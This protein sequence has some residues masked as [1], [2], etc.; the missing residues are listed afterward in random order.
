MRRSLWLAV[1][2]AVP[3]VGQVQ[4]PAVVQ[5]VCGACHPVETATSQRRTRAEWQENIGQMVAR[6]AKGT[7]EEL[8]AVLDYFARNNGPVTAPSPAS[9]TG[10]PPAGGPPPGGRA[11]R[12]AAYMPGSAD[13]HVVDVAAADRGRRVYAAEC[14]NCHG[15]HAR[16]GEKGADL[17]RSEV[18]L[19]DRYG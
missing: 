5:K 16:G 3:A 1:L 17:V 12:G 18:V 15:A 13:K 11:G 14:I 9:P 7:D 10:G 19:H 2:L 6:G 8:A 4:P